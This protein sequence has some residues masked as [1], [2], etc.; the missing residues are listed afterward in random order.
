MNT[1]ACAGRAGRRHHG[2]AREGRDRPQ[3]LPVRE[4]GAP[5]AA[6]PLRRQRRQPT[7]GHCST[8]C[9]RTAAA[10]ERRPG[11]IETTL[12]VHPRVLDDF[13][14]FNDFLD[15]PMRRWPSSVS[16]ANCRWRAFTPTTASR[17]PK[18]DDIENCSN[19]SPYP[20]LHLLRESSIER[21][22]A[23][24]P[25]AARDLRAQHR[26]AAPPG[27]GRLGA[28]VDRARQRGGGRGG[29]LISPGQA[30]HPSLLPCPCPPAFTPAR[31]PSGGRRPMR[32]GAAPHPGSLAD[33][34][35]DTAS[36]RCACLRRQPAAAGRLRI[37]AATRRPVRRPAVRAPVLRGA[38][39]LVVCEAAEPAVKLSARSQV[40]AQV[41]LLGTRRSPMRRW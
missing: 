34:L 35:L 36:H 26:D 41:A 6:D 30:M 25:D 7:R 39:I 22:V 27:T 14:D 5:E 9:A 23:A 8:N 37:G 29:A 31:A 20:T 24:F 18:P 13:L 15:V 16:T 33:E 32:R 4:G 11:E 2:L 12:L 19:R 10:G 21:A 17:A 40:A 1:G 3:P 28:A 38:A